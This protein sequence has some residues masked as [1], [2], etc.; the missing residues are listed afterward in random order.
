[1]DFALRAI[2]S[3]ALAFAMGSGCVALDPVDEVA[4]SIEYVS[5]HAGAFVMGSPA[6]EPG[7]MANEGPQHDVA[8]S[9]FELGKYEVTNA[10]YARFLEVHPDVERPAHWHPEVVPLAEP[11][12]GMTWNEA[13]QFASWVG[14]RLP[15]EAEWEYAARAGT[16]GSR[17]G[18]VDAIAWHIGNSNDV[19]RDVGTKEP[20]AWG[21]YDMLGNVHE[22][23]ADG[24][25]DYTGA[26][27][28]DPLHAPTHDQHVLRGGSFDDPDTFSRAAF[29]LIREPS[30]RVTDFGFRVA[31]R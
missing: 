1:M 3:C 4:P 27:E 19:K 2:A 26:P 8:I 10:E 30:R 21:L 23:V 25:V 22:W 15:T 16:T 28:S 20:N 6:D 12:V 18:A 31:R 29:R 5:I 9:A 24:A 11:A 13:A 17:Y 14:A 7:R